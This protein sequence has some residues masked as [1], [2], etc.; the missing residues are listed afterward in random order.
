MSSLGTYF[1][2]N[3]RK[4]IFPFSEIEPFIPTSGKILDVGCGH[5]TL[6]KLLSENSSS[7]NILG[8]DPS[9]DKIKVAKTIVKSKNAKFLSTTIEK[10]PS[11]KYDIIIIVDVLYLM[12]YEDKL[13]LLKEAKK[14]LKDNGTLLLKEIVRTNSIIN[15]LITF[16]EFLMMN[17]FRLTYSNAKKSEIL[18]QSEHVDLLKKV[19][20]KT[21]KVKKINAILPYPHTLFVTKIK[22]KK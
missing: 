12:P 9:R 11:E 7:R 17:V 20:L 4:I 21:N 15:Y 13:Q 22:G 10:L 5:G 16:E 3:I 6:V 14:R 8:I 18:T 1:F 2:I 19:G